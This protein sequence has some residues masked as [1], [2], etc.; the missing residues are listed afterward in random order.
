MLQRRRDVRLDGIYDVRCGMLVRW[1]LGFR[2]A[3]YV[4]FLQ[5]LWMVLLNNSVLAG[6]SVKVMPE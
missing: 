4:F 3:L 1:G 2:H 6:D 5:L